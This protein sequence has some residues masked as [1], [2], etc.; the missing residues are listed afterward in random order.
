MEKI[1]AIVFQNDQP[2]SVVTDSGCVY[3]VEYCKR[4]QTL[5]WN[6][7]G[8]YGINDKKVYLEADGGDWFWLDPG[9]T[10]KDNSGGNIAG[11]RRDHIDPKWLSGLESWGEESDTVYCCICDDNLPTDEVVDNVCD[12][13][14]WDSKDCWWAGKGF[15]G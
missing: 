5:Y 15:K 1:I 7:S 4:D 2:F 14:H 10:A 8:S 3:D 13:V 9:F 12:H 11:K 6:C